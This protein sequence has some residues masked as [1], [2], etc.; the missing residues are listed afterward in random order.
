[1]AIG[2]VQ[3]MLGRIWSCLIHDQVYG[4]IELYSHTVTGL[5]LCFQFVTISTTMPARCSRHLALR[6][7]GWAET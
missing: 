7:H 3:V 6:S 5:H 2:I 4:A 1:M